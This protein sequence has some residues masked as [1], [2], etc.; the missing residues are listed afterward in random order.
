MANP[1][2]KMSK[3]VHVLSLLAL[4]AF[5]AWSTG[6]RLIDGWSAD[7]GAHLRFSS[8]YSVSDFLFD[9]E[10]LWIASFAH[11]TPI[12]NLFY[13]FNLDQWGLDPAGWRVSMVLLSVA[14]VAAFHAA[15]KQY[16]RASLALFVTL[17]W[18]LSVPFFYTSAT[19]MTSHY[20]V[21][22]LAASLCVWSYVRW[23][24]HGNWPYLVGAT[25]LY[26]VAAFSKE[27]FLPLPGLLLLQ[28]PWRRSALGMAP[29]AAVL[30]GYLACRYFVLGTLIGGYRQGQYVDS[31]D[32]LSL[33]K[34]AAHLAITL[35][36]GY[37][38]LIVVALVVLIA[39]L[40]ATYPLRIFALVAAVLGV[41]PLL[42]LMGSWHLPEP[43]RYFFVLSAVTLFVIGLLLEASLQ[44]YPG[45]PLT[46]WLGA[47]LVMTVLLQ[48]YLV[49][50]PVLVQGFGMQAAIF[51][52]ALEHRERMLILNPGL[53]AD[54]SYW[55]H[56][57]NNIRETQARQQGH[58]T[59][60]KVLMVS[61]PQAPIVF[62]LHALNVP[63]YRYDAANCRCLVPH[64]PS[65][66]ADAS[67]VSVVPQQTMQ[68]HLT[69]PASRPENNQSAW[70]QS[71][72]TARRI[73][74]NNPSTLEITGYV[75]LNTELD[76]LYLV[77]PF[78]EK[79]VIE[80]TEPGA[81]V[82]VANG[83]LQRPFRLRLRFTTPQL[84]AQARDKLCIAV[85]SILSS[86]YALLLGQPD[87]CNVFVNAT[88]RRPG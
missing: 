16:M 81:A 7:D 87:Y 80:P 3:R 64:V 25:L 9:P 2:K 43:D 30:L 49:R 23:V 85:P 63:I 47:V 11:L 53:P 44:R 69:D 6:G 37:W 31:K 60:Q 41:L 1:A 52:H 33:A 57:L 36:G 40:R 12:L 48:Q 8:L 19:Y 78:H 58:D 68:L 15:V 86:P 65:G 32:I 73:M 55:S 82:M 21:G 13:S 10:L 71:A 83:E 18:A 88:L 51:M 74:S 84:A 42:P 17:G 5:V 4:L 72:Q 22:M 45:R 28:R 27:V 26:A 75:H 77:L 34:N 79:G 70:G 56:A 76:W 62:G 35:Y 29:L 66:V 67:P 20:M 59:Y 54:D 61:N 39:L 24:R 14:T 38:Q 46:T 50:I